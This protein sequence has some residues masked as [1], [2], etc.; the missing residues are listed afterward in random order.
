MLIVRNISVLLNQK[1]ILKHVSFSANSGCFT[2]IVGPNGCGKTTLLRSLTGEI[3]Y[4][5]KIWLNHKNIA[6]LKPWQMAEMRAVLPQSVNL[7]FP[8]KVSEVVRIGL[9]TGRFGAQC[10]L[11]LQALAKVGLAHYADRFFHDLSGGEQ[12]RVNLAR[13]IAQVWFPI[14]HGVP[15]WL[16]L[17]EPVASLDV[18]YQLEVMQLAKAYASAGG[19]VIAVMH[20]L[21]LSAMYADFMI[22]LCG[23]QILAFGTPAEVMTDEILSEA[24]KCDLRVNII[25]EAQ[26]TYLLPDRIKLETSFMTE[27]AEISGTETLG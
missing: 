10:D 11:V 5:G 19:G 12:Q 21:N 3:A 2:A 17:D 1:T 14:E 20:D 7:S 23:G 18:A 27:K 25:P 22:I 24:Y 4:D 15:R 9:Q 13:V 6:D 26:K 16:L 8:F